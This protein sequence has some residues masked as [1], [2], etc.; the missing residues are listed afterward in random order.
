MFEGRADEQ[1]KIRGFRIEPAEV[2]TVLA[3]HESVVQVAVVAREDQPG[4]KRLVAYVVGDAD[5]STLREFA[6][7]K[8]PD[9]MV[10]AAFVSLEAIPVTRNGKLDRSALPAPAF[11]GASSGRAAATPDEELLCEVFADVL[12][13][14]R[15]GAEDSF[16]ALGGDSIMSMLVVSRARRAGLLLSA[17]QVFELRTPAALARAAES[18]RVD[19]PVERGTGAVPL[20]PVMLDVLER[21]GA[22]ALSGPFGQSMLAIVPPG[23]NQ[24]RLGAALRAVV[25]HHD[26]LRARLRRSQDGTWE[27]DVPPPGGT[28]VP[29][30]RVRTPAPDGSALD[31]LVEREA[32]R[33]DPRAGAMVRAVWFDAGRDAPGRLLLVVHHLVVDGVSWRVLLP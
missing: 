30:R 14:E 2:E 11:A 19:E 18:G 22:A 23:L 29:L 33:L 15:V 3:A 24:N 5:E 17:R 9:Y 28:E 27:L 1:V 7:A 25:D 16:F 20:T 6:A 21:S 13:L 26:M 4:V 8:L 31:D 32:A 12:G 10:P